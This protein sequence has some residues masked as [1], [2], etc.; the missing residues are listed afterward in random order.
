MSNFI[1]LLIV[2][3]LSFGQSIQFELWQDD[4]ALI[5]KLQ[6]LEEAVGV[7]GSGPLGLGAYRYIAVPYIP[8]YQLF[9]LN[10]PIFYVWAIFFYFLATISIYFLAKQITKNNSVSTLSG[11]IFAAGFIG[12]DG[13]LRLFN[14]IQTSYSIILT[15][16]VFFYLFKLYKSGKSTDYLLSVVLF[17]LS[18][19]TAFIRTQYLILPVISW[20]LIFFVNWKKFKEI[21]RST[22]L[23]LPFVAVYSG[24][25]FANPDARFGTVVEFIN[26]LVS[27]HIEYSHGFFASLGNVVIPQPVTEVFFNFAGLTSLDF[28][29]RLLLLELTFLVIFLSLG[30]LVLRKKVRLFI[31]LFGISLGWL[32]VQWIFF[33]D[34]DLLSRYSL[35]ESS[36]M[37]WANFTGGIFIIASLISLRVIFDKNRQVFMLSLVFLI[38]ILSN[39]LV[40]SIYLPFSP[41][42]SINRYLV[43][44]L[45]GYALFLSLVMFYL[46]GKKSFIFLSLIIALNIG[47]SIDYQKKFI[48]EKSIPTKKFYEELKTLVPEIEK[49]SIFYFDIADDEL[50]QQEFRDFFSVGSMPDSTA[51]AIRYNIDRYDFDLTSNFDEFIRILNEKNLPEGKVFSFF[52][53]SS[54][55]LID[56]S[57]L[58]RNNLF[59]GA[60]KT[61]KLDLSVPGIFPV[62]PVILEFAARIKPDI[63][64]NKNCY[65]NISKD[66]K[67]LFFNYLLSR[68]SFRSQ[69]AVKTSS[70]EKYHNTYFL[71]D[72]KFN[73]LWR[74]RRGWWIENHKEE[75]VIDLG[76]VKEISQILWV[77]GYANSTPTDYTIEASL[78]GMSWMKLK[79]VLLD[80]KKDDGLLTVEDF[81]PV[82]AGFIKMVIIDTFDRDSPTAGEIEVVGRDFSDI[83]KFRLEDL[84]SQAYCIKDEEEKNIL[85]NFISSAGIEVAVSW[86]TDKSSDNVVRLHVIADGRY[87][88]HKVFLPAGGI[89]LSDL[90]I[91]PMFTSAELSLSNIRVI[92]PNKRQLYNEKD[93]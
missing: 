81:E 59:D 86:K 34:A 60:E 49:G 62:T 61:G 63:D 57:K 51:I 75:I 83:D 28:S 88:N 84:E 42:E 16:G 78:D 14:S 76:G 6:H 22:V 74:G 54:S 90:K 65:S 21:F 37:V 93:D 82:K 41:L 31:F 26:G 89:K 66:E 55:G 10:I 46:M 67:K 44:S 33:H 2:I 80:T 5:F 4:N 72:G 68:D 91:E 43:H 25:F 29:N 13:I 56:T 24:I 85:L 11:A 18:L 20:F 53:S 36:K 1:T 32:I 71:L 38:W 48:T 39:I 27:G 12:S 92:Y 79:K 15:A 87:H 19:E 45:A 8:I 69:S 47:L 77:N 7:F 64:I 40:Y 23:L 3:L 70:E 9:G 30:A 50:S 17:Y 52:Y 58:V 73:T 35:E